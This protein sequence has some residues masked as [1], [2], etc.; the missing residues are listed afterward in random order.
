MKKTSKIFVVFVMLMAMSTLAF[1]QTT[2]LPIDFEGGVGSVTFTDFDGGSTSIIT[3]PDASGINT[4]SYVA[5]HVRNEVQTWA[6]T[7]MTLDSALD[8][9]T[10]NTFN[11][12]VYSPNVGIPV[13]FKLENPDASQSTEL[14]LDTSVANEWEELSY[15]FDGATTGLYTKI[16]IIFN[17][18]VMGD[19]SANSTYYFD[20]IEFVEGSTMP[21]PSVAAPTPTNAATDVI[22]VY[23][24][25]YTNLAGTNFNPSWGQSTVVTIDYPIAG[26]NTLKYESL[27]Y[28]GTNLGSTNGDAPQDVSAYEYL[29]VDFWTPNSTDLGIY[30]ISSGPVEVEYVLIPTGTLE[31]WNSVDIPLTAFAGVDLAN[32]IQFKV[33]GNGTIYFDNWYFWKAPA[34]ADATLSDLQVDGTTVAGFSPNTLNYTVELPYGTS[35]V[36]TVTATTNDPNATYDI[37]DAASLPGT[38]TVEVTAD[39]GATTLTYNVNFTLEDPEPT[40]AAPIPPLPPAEVI[41]IF[42]NAYTDV[43]VDT[44][45]AT[46]DQ[47]DV[48]D[49]QI[50]GDD[51]KKYTNLTYAGIEFTSN[52]IDASSMD[53]F[54]MD[55]WTPDVIAKE[56]EAFKIKLVDFGADGAWS[57]GDDVEA[58]L[59]FDGTTSPALISQQWISFDIPLAEFA[60]AGMTTQAHLAQLVLSGV[61]DLNTVYVDNV[62]LYSGP[63]LAVT[64]SSFTAAYAAQTPTIYWTTQSESNNSGWN[65]YRAESENYADAFCINNQLIAG[66]GTTSEPT[67]YSYND[68][69]PVQTG[70]TY[71]YWLESVEI[72]GKTESY[73][74]ITLDIPN[75]NET[76]EL[77]QKTLLKGNYPNPFNPETVI[78]FQVKEGNS[79]RL[80]IYNAKGQVLETATVNPQQTEYTWD[81][82]NYG[83]GIYFYKLETENFSQIKKMI[84]L[85]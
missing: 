59:T 37:T 1:A 45:S 73:G 27:N 49:V 2:S 72:D 85:K 53:N 63:T 74:P 35:T 44:W 50:A 33:E 6:G 36:P 41:S 29:H 62:Y 14:S 11:I 71:W 30:L 81:G 76:P 31:E 80:T 13:L 79:G 38:T 5:E 40:A 60:A 19:G 8:F 42:S 83:S 68:F 43:T 21:T 77:P 61:S 69:Y 55:I 16:V 65:L 17:N 9:T 10:N 3:N 4:S 58:E 22:S 66:A 46:W 64:L 34:S 26:N 75:E 78:N 67:N 12:K 18:G 39:D 57:G 56:G 20:D 54:H 15:N 52:T 47:A 84:M 28:Q 82:S 32:V 48:E 23:S 51:A 25:A 70:Q 24:D 7:Y